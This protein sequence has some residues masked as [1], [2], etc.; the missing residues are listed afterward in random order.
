VQANISTITV[1]QPGTFNYTVTNTSNGC[2]I[3]G[4]QTVTQ[5]T[6]TPVV[7]SAVSSVLNCTTTSVNASATTTSTP[8]SY[9][10]SGPGIT[11]SSLIQEQLLLTKEA[12]Y[13]YT[14]TN[15]SNGCRTI[16]T[17]AVTQNTT[18][19]SASATGGTLTC[20]NTTIRNFI[21]WTCFRSNIFMEWT[22]FI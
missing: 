16:G 15:T 18:A 17:Q 13:N 8:V 12:P 10:W 5:N 20:S 22:R 11:C 19:P 3:G 21:G 2:S 1:N 9:N 4:S 6:A 14:V 7:T